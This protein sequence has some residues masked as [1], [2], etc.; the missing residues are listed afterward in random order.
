[1]D[2]GIKN[3]SEGDMAN[4]FLDSEIDSRISKLAPTRTEMVER[5]DEI[6]LGADEVITRIEKVNGILIEITK[7]QAL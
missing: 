7:K 2:A 4:R 6:K 5:V 3:N 1:M